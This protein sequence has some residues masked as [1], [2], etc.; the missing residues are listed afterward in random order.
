MRSLWAVSTCGLV[1]WCKSS[2]TSCK[3]LN[4]SNFK[5]NIVFG[6]LG[7]NFVTDRYGRRKS[8]VVAAIMF[9]IG[10]IIQTMTG[11]YG[12]LMFGRVFVGVG[13]GFGLALDVSALNSFSCLQ[14]KS[15]NATGRL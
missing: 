6:A 10:S 11:S 5:M 13:V 12:L 3:K 8:F 14:T 15:S 4:R 7:S 9:I 2:K 1:S